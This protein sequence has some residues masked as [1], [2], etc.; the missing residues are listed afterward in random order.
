MEW[1][2]VWK[3]FAGYD[4]V[5]KILQHGAKFYKFAIRCVKS[6][7]SP[8]NN[9]LIYFHSKVKV[10]SGKFRGYFGPFKGS[11]K[12]H[13]RKQ[14]RRPVC[15]A[16]EAWMTERPSRGLKAN[17]CDSRSTANLAKKLASET[18]GGT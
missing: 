13:L 11:A 9:L 16:T 18:V 17:W 8:H 12:Q 5:I 2:K 4:K 10:Q 7:T 15:W 14:V 3:Y 6:T 1:T